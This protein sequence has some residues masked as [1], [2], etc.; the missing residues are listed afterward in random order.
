ML[1]Q[2]SRRK[3]YRHLKGHRTSRELLIAEWVAHS[4]LPYIHRGIANHTAHDI[5]HSRR[6]IECL[7]KLIDL[8]KVN[9]VNLTQKEILIMLIAAWLHDIGNLSASKRTN[10]A[11]ESWR[12]ISILSKRDLRL[13][14]L[15]KPLEFVVRYHQSS[16]DIGE[17]PDREFR[18][19][20]E[21][22][23]LRLICSMF[24][25]AD[26]CDMG[27]ERAS[28]IAYLLLS[29]QFSD[30][31]KKHWRANKAVQS[32]DFDVEKEAVVITVASKRTASF[33]TKDFR[34]KFA[35]IEPYIRGMLPIRKVVVREVPRSRLR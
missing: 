27:E 16:R 17:V 6:T 1:D 13:G 33:L 14:A 35:R 8:A 34:K 21:K 12:M 5:G 22:V 9:G 4:V 26:D 30:L 3:V 31:E 29:P 2:S 19:D 24:R 20:G 7:N 10:H 18:I 28:D 15:M 23:R 32:V 25:I 11:D